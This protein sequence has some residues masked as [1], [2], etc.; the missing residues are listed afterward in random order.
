MT[1][2]QLVNAVLRRL[3]EQE[4]ASLTSPSE[5][6]QLIMDIINEAKLDVE[7]RWNWSQLRTSVDVTTAASDNS[8]NLTGTNE[9]TTLLDAYNVSKEWPLG[10][11]KNNTWINFNNNSSSVEESS[12]LYYD[13]VGIDTANNSEVQIRVWPT[14]SGVETLRFYCVIP[15]EDLSAASDILKVPAQPVIQGAYLRAINERGEDNGRLSEIQEA[16]FT[17]VLSDAISRDALNY[18]EELVWRAI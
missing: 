7:E 2:L 3:R 15:Q 4:V 8:Y 13:V 16:L 5:Y 11:V 6:V 9:R 12:P 17:R 18:E 14:P 1:Y 10:H